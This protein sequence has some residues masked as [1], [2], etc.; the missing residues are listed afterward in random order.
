MMPNEPIIVLK[1]YL[2][3]FIAP[4]LWVLVIF[5]EILILWDCSKILYSYE[6]DS[7]NKSAIGFLKSSKWTYA[8]IKVDS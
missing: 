5:V 8:V 2:I 4:T 1:E 3:F 6:L 7:L